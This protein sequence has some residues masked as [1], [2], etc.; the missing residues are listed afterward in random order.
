M[1]YSE[2]GIRKALVTGGTRGIGYAI[3]EMLVRNGIEV[4]ISGTNSETV[5]RAAQKLGAAIAIAVDLEQPDAPNVLISQAVKALGGLDL[6]V[7]NAGISLQA[8]L[9]ETSI[10][11]W[12][13]I[14]H[15]NARAP[16]FICKEALVHLRKS[17]C[18]TI[19]QI[20]SVVSHE[21]YPMQS[22][23]AASKHALVGFTK[24]LAKEVQPDGIRI[25]TISP[26]GVA[27]DMIDAVRPDIDH[28]ALID[29]QEIADLVWF[30]LS[31]R[32]N[33]MVDHIDVRRNLKT[34]W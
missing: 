26:G 27:T 24:S 11:A 18:P 25:H 23:Y 15:I 1:D 10:S 6:V 22:A 33:A 28:D 9:E 12:D 16:Y 14:M 29:P 34:P 31:H 3:A 7:N 5:N 19:I 32:G 8:S 13:R 21:G 4:C 2:V 17:T 20:A 30:L